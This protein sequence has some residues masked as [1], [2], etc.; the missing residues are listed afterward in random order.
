V[1]AALMVACAGASAKTEESVAAGPPPASVVVSLSF[2]ADHGH[3]GWLE[4]GKL[5]ESLR[6]LT[7][8]PM[9]GAGTS[10]SGPAWSPDGRQIAFVRRARGASGVYTVASDGSTLTRIA[11]LVLNNAGYVGIGWSPDGSN[12][13]FDRFTDVECRSKKPFRLRFTIAS[14]T[15]KLRD[16][17]ALPRP[18]R[19]VGL[20]SVWWLP[21]GKRLSY[22]V[23]E[24]GENECYGHVGE[25][26]SLLYVIGSDG[27]GR[28]L[29]ARGVYFSDAEWS[30]DGRRIAYV[31]YG[32]SDIDI[33]VVAADG[34]GKRTLRRNVPLDVHIAWKP[35]GSAIAVVDS[36]RLDLVDPATGQTRTLRR[37]TSNDH[38][39]DIAWTP[40]GSAIA[41][42]DLQ[43]LDLVDPATGHT[44]TLVR[45][46]PNDN[47]YGILGFSPDGQ[48]LAVGGTE[49]SMR[50]AL[51]PIA[52]GTPATYEPWRKAPGE[53]L[54]DFDLTFH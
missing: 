26:D 5:G 42:M 36:H 7:P 50:I 47:P 24:Y 2:S 25:F 48:W 53:S 4:V 40:D 10:D 51:V 3:V 34:S 29:L 9:L 17:D 1:F 52:G 20:Q 31:L 32:G 49:S 23:N 16:V 38:A 54:D 18:R 6:P 13:V 43:Q 44:R 12:L 45:W 8:R 15:G 30:P 35:D 37:W 22:I 46:T 21:D 19:L 14:P 39:P 11:P 28:K 27:R 33:D 41:V